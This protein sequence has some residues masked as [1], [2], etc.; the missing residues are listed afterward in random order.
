M[1]NNTQEPV[2]PQCNADCACNT[3]KGLSLRT[4]L[5]FLSIILLVA[6]AV[7]T[8]SILRKSR[9]VSKMP[10]SGY[11]A[12]LSA[13]PEI[14]KLSQGP[15]KDSTSG[16]AGQS[17]SY[18]SLPSL[19]SLDTV[20]QDVDGVFILLVNNESEKPPALMRDVDAAASAIASRGL[21]MRSFQLK[22]DAPDFAMVG[23]QLSPPCVL[24][25]FKGR[26]MRGVPA[27]VVTQD[28]LLQ[29]CLAAMQ[30]SSCC[31]AGGKRVCK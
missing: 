1:Q 14:S 20:A 30:P 7:L 6:G 25:L 11:A 18:T 3:K 23:S 29:A 12:A 28:K 26:G 21:H 2:S 27:A 10:S 16:P 17:P 22:K 19:A 8:S 13:N 4:K 5:V 31:A 24:V 9:S 15:K